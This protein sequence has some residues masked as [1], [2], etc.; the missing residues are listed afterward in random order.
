MT[1][2]LDLIKEYYKYCCLSKRI[3]L[4]PRCVAS[5]VPL[6]LWYVTGWLGQFRVLTPDCFKHFYLPSFILQ[7]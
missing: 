4:L 7:L 2:F 3:A 6:R 1:F 5:L